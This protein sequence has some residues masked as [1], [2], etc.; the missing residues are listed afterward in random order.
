MRSSAASV[1][2]KRITGIFALML[3]QILL[4]PQAQ[5]QHTSGECPP[6]TATVT[7]GG[8]VTIN[9]SDCEL[10]GFGGIGAIDGGSF[11]AADFENHGTAITRRVG[12]GPTTQWFLDYSHN[13][14]TGIG[15]TDVFELSDGS[16]AGS[17]D[18]QFTITIN[19]SASPITVAPSNLPTLTAGTFFSQTLTA[20]GGASPYTYTL[21]SGALPI[22]LSLSSGGVL[23][24]TPTQR[25]AYSF[26]VRATDSTT[27]TAQ[28][29]DKG[30][31]GTVQSPALALSPG[32]YAM[33]QGVSG[34]FSIGVSGG[35]APYSF[36]V[37]PVPPNALPPGLSLS[38]SGVISGIPTSSGTFNTTIRVGD[39]STGPGTYFEL[40]TLTI[41][42]APPPSVSIAVSPSS[43]NEDGATNLTYTVTRSATSTSALTVNLTYSG[44][45]TSGSDYTGAAATVVIPA[46]A[47]TA[48]LTLDP[49]ADTT[50]ESNETA[51]VTVAAG[52][53]YTIGAPSS[54]TD[55][56]NPTRPCLAAT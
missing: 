32:T 42:V 18:I 20:T 27:P 16:L 26:S 56:V 25:G 21:Q 2:L 13:G 44:T 19:A 53:G 33:S 5:A 4:I 39:A 54:A 35:V 10:P 52:S 45:A 15:A 37:E 38:A 17:G 28:F 9:I 29:T 51:I 23:S 22:G 31:T 11:G 7:A 36:L 24:G 6:Q 43:V 46:N 50:S 14:T 47:T 41:N 48:T 12:S 30:Y 49:T 8:T 55:L 1:W 40:E 34:S 3:A